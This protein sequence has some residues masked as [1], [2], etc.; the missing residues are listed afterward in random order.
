MKTPNQ[1][2]NKQDLYS[3]IEWTN[4]NF[5][6]LARDTGDTIK[7]A[8]FLEKNNPSLEALDNA[9]LMLVNGRVADHKAQVPM[10]M[11][12]LLKGANINSMNSEGFTP[13][14]IAYKTGNTDLATIILDRNPEKGKESLEGL[15]KGMI[16]TDYNGFTSDY[17]FLDNPAKVEG[18]NLLGDIPD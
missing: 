14:Q 8:E 7:A 17:S 15:K 18:S 6:A 5:P 9:L 16:Y 11:L 13:L 4:E 1:D 10:L 2:T 12:L 3:T